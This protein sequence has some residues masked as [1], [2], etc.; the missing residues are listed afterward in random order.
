VL[1]SLLS[2]PSSR[3]AVDL[4]LEPPSDREIELYRESV[5]Q[6]PNDPDAHRNLGA[7]LYFKGDLNSAV[8]EF[9]KCIDLRPG[10]P[11]FHNDLGVAL[12]QK[13]DQRAAMDEF[14][15]ASRLDPNR[16]TNAW[17]N[18]RRTALRS[19]YVAEARRK[20]HRYAEAEHAAEQPAGSASTGAEGG[21]NAAAPSSAPAEPSAP[22]PP[23]E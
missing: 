10:D 7:A 11:S 21:S 6:R 12:Y 1:T 16:T 23:N 4:K 3:F 18:A 17:Y 15:I 13:G 8:A 20:D 19:E 5:R 2:S 14:N 9:R 22:E